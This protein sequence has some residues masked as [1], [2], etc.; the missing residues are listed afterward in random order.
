MHNTQEEENT[1]VPPEYTSRP[2]VDLLV[3][4]IIPTVILIKFSGDDFLGATNA[5]IIALMFPLGWGLFE[6]IKNK[7][8]NFIAGL[9]LISILLTGGIGL[10]ELDTQWLA[11]KEATIPAIISIAIITSTYTRYPL[12]KTFIYNPL[13]M[14]VNKIKQRLE[15]FDNTKA[16]EK[17]LLKATYFLSATFFFSAIVNY[18]LASLIVVSP[19]GTTAFNEELGRL[20]MLSY[21]II[22]LP[23]MFM[24]VGISYYLS[25][26]I[27]KMTGLKYTEIYNN[28]SE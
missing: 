11:I 15:E 16:F 3:S 14:N 26:K 6:R 23:S 21:P 19:A 13:I 22:V 20:T 2:M 12:I 5:L 17:M 25:H 18:I 28:V 27:H 10:L 7:K 8:N 1:K 9:G 24:I 4:I